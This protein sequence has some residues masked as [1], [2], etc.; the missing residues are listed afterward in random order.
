[1]HIKGKYSWLKHLDFMVLDILSLVVAFV[2]AI[3]IRFGDF[4][5]VTST[6]WKTLLLIAC[7]MDLLVILF[8]NPFSG[9]FRRYGSEELLKAA[10][11]TA[12]N[13]L[14][15]FVLMYVLKLG[16][17]YSR[18]TVFLMYALYFVLSLTL[19][20]IWK[21][22]L[23]SGKVGMME[24]IRKSIFVVGTREN[25]PDLL[26]SINSGFFQAYSV[27]GICIVDGDLGEKVTARIDETD[28]N[29]RVKETFLE[30]QN[31]TKLDGIVELILNNR[32]SELYV[33]VK[34]SVLDT[35]VY[36]TLLE[37]GKGIHLGIRPMIG[38][39]AEDQFITTVGT[40]KALGIGMHSVT[41]EQMVY[42]G[43]KRLADIV[44]GLVGLIC[45]LPLMLLVKVSFLLTGDTKPI[46]YTQTRVGLN[47]QTFKMYKFRSMVWN[48]GEVLQELLK[49]PKYAKE[50]AEN[51]KFEDDP[52]ITKVGKLLRK[53]SLDEVP[54]FLNVLKGDM[55][56]IGPRP[57]VVGELEEHG[58]LQ[59]YNHVKPG[60]TGWW[61]C[62]GRSNTT[63][64]ERLELEYYYVKNC[65][66]YLDALCVIKTIVV[67]LKRDGAK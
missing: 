34:P 24:K 55:S 11:L 46:F 59:L 61:G 62:N 12:Y 35:E 4:S 39:D 42:Q 30:F 17:H 45:L 54:Q 43:V 13:G 50:W 1:M 8:T 51:Q 31:A 37:N 16:T 48:A 5:L 21:R 63:Y 3:G 58:G 9:I 23:R 64:E 26:R 49:D 40:Y 53:T 29:G 36:Q 47:G 15:L 14:L 52:R 56:V 18:L 57:L 20:M 2:M 66:P 41:G 44:F 22:V 27:Q 10:T 7:L 6:S 32:I 25:M 60:I 19:R 67:I 33:G 65:S 38:F 28:D